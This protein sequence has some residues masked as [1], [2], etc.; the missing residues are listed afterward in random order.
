MCLQRR[1][2]EFNS[3]VRKIPWRMEWLPTPVFLP[4]EFPGVTES[5]MT[6]LLPHFTSL[7]FTTYPYCFY[8]AILA[9]SYNL[10]W[11]DDHSILNK[12]LKNIYLC[13]FGCAG[14]VLLLELCSSCA[15]WGPLSGCGPWASHRSGFCCGPWALGPVGS[16]VAVPGL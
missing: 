14:S 6:E 15:E 7:H 12:F 5:D 13:I 10:G 11:K 9:K 3:W 8:L 4:G 1:R 2:P 16:G